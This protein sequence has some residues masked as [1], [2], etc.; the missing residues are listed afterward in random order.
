MPTNPAW[1]KALK[2]SGPQ[3]SELLEQE[4][5]KSKLNIDQL[6]DFMFTREHL[7]RRDRILDVIENDPVFDKSQNYFKGRNTRMETSLARAK[8]LRQ[9][10]VQHKWSDAEKT[11]ANE[12]ISEP[13]VYGLHDGM[14]LKTIK[15]QGTPEQHKLFLEDAS[16]YKIIGC[17]AQ[18]ELVRALMIRYGYIL[19]AIGPW[20]QRAR[21]RD[22]SDVECERQDI[23]S[24]LTSSYSLEV[25][26][27]LFG[28]DSH[29]RRRDGSVDHQ[30]EVIWSS[31]LRRTHQRSEDS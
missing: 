7:D 11:I 4:R 25:V 20:L 31:P 23:H 17:Y 22:D 3:G 8:R 16:N 14:F 1:V 9:L 13:T 19:T 12:L 28:Q 30:W 6:A 18:T 29:T 21:S 26:D 15:E 24:Q 2:P 27:W 5:A 10:T